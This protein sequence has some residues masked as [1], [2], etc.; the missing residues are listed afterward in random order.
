MDTP[1]IKPVFGVFAEM[2]DTPL[3]GIEVTI[4][5][6]LRD[7]GAGTETLSV[8]PLAR[9]LAKVQGLALAQLLEHHEASWFY[10]T[11]D[12]A[13]KVLLFDLAEQIGDVIKPDEPS[14]EAQELLGQ[15]VQE[16]WAAYQAR[17]RK[18]SDMDRF[19]RMYADWLKA[20]S[21]AWTEEA[22]SAFNRALAQAR[23]KEP[24]KA[25]LTLRGM[26]VTLD[27]IDG[28][29]RTLKGTGM[30]ILSP[31]YVSQPSLDVF[32]RGIYGYRELGKS[33]CLWTME[34]FIRELSD[35]LADA[36]P[37]VMPETADGEAAAEE[38]GD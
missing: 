20:L 4:A 28:L 38:S 14:P 17:V 27:R 23:A 35:T 24:A 9:S 31:G 32:Q 30:C 36:V 33:V 21:E 12:D 25:M 29:S 8:R 6:L 22:D 2:Q 1:S 18:A 19:S 37:D 3:P 5:S 11:F 10:E 7:Y 13:R 15:L 26:R 34:D 16:H